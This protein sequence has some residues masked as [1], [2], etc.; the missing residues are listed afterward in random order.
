MYIYELNITNPQ[1]K[2]DH[3]EYTTL[4]KN[5]ITLD[6]IFKHYFKK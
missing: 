1:R 3:P 2:I 6:D 4:A 5:I